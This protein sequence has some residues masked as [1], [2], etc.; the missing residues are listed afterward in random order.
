[1]IKKIHKTREYLDYL[2][3]HYNNVQESWKLV[4]EK[5]SDMQIMQHR[6]IIEQEVLEH[7]DSKMSK[8]EFVQY[9][10][11]FYPINDL[12]KEKSD[13]EQAWIHHKINNNHH[14]E[15]WTRKTTAYADVFV[16]LNVID[17]IAMGVKNKNT[18]LEYYEYSK[19]KIDIPQWAED[20]MY[21]MFDRVYPA[22]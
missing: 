6:T 15:H 14:W 7:D 20:L 12:E 4:Q 8:E 3:E 9:R 13:F 19:D 16:V 22:K 1:V 17:W 18:A 21:E 10:E 2:E 11:A 5:C